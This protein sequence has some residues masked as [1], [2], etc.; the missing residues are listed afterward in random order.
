MGL[1]M[2]GDGIPMAFNLFSGNQNEQPSMKPLE[3]DIIRNFGFE[4]FVVCTD[5]GPGSETNRLF[6]DIEDRAFVVTQSLKKLK[7]E[8]RESAMNDEGWRRVS[9][10][11]PVDIREIRENPEQF[12]DMLYYKEEPY[13]TPKV[14]GQILYVTYSPSYAI[15]QKNIRDKQIKRPKTSYHRGFRSFFFYSAVKLGSIHVFSIWQ[16]FFY[17]HRTTDY[18]V[19]IASSRFFRPC[20]FTSVNVFSSSRREFSPSTSFRVPS[21]FTRISPSNSYTL[22]EPSGYSKRMISP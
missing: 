18:I 5:G 8:E 9:D 20:H 21:S 4:R 6:N 12:K 11:K 16:K 2:D 3:Q 14:P 1:F 17:K 13:G 22:T 7:K 10:N 15:Y 19:S